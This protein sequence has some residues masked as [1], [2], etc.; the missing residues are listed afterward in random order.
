MRKIGE[1]IVFAIALLVVSDVAH[2]GDRQSPKWRQ[3]P[4]DYRGIPFGAS[5]ADVASKLKLNAAVACLLMGEQRGCIHHTSIDDVKAMEVFQFEEDQLVQV[6]ISFKADRYAKLRDLFIERYG[7]PAETWT[8]PYE[9][10]GGG[11]HTTEILE[12]HGDK[13]IVHIEQFGPSLHEGTA[14]IA[15]REWF[16]KPD[17]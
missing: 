7:Q 12:W 8:E 5:E 9:T 17:D 15:T 4:K 6:F 16:E 14:V 2:A 11:D 13:M 10:V 1:L 3:E